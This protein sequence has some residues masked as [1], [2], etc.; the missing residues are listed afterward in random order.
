MSHNYPKL[1]AYLVVRREGLRPAHWCP[2]PKKKNGPKN[3]PENG[4]QIDPQIGP[5]H[6]K[7]RAY[8]LF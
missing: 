6:G 5:E 4:P 7:K 3:G 1:K 2:I 8:F